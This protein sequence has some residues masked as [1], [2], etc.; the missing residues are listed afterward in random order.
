MLYDE[1][2][3]EEQRQSVRDAAP[4]AS[5]DIPSVVAPFS[6]FVEWFSLARQVVR[7]PN[8]MCLSTATL[9]GHPRGRF[10]LLKRADPQN[11]YWVTNYNSIKGQSLDDN[12]KASLAFYW[13]AFYGQ[14]LQR[15][16]IVSG[17]VSKAS[18]EMSEKFFHARPRES[19]IGAWTSQQSETISSRQV[20]DSNYEDKIKQFEGTKVIPLPP[21]WGA[22][23]LNVEV[24]E[25]W[26]G[27]RGRMHDRL[28][29][30]RGEAH[31]WTVVRL[32]P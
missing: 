12:P 24:F 20:L 7:E 29:F 17:S 23:Q 8:A 4:A 25:F 9:D 14:P 28:R 1:S 16:V 3:S 5:L 31:N 18:T 32:Q 30:S 6:L 22:F 26:Q 11:F 27:K 15:Q 19:Q 13:Q 2:T 21:H 10:I